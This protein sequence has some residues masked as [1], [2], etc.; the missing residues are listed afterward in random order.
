MRI[1]YIYRLHLDCDG[2]LGGMTGHGHSDDLWR[3]LYDMYD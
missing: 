1:S 3:M 2:S